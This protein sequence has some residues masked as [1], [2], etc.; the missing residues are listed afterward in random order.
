MQDEYPNEWKTYPYPMFIHPSTH[1]SSI[2]D[3][4]MKG[5]GGLEPISA[6]IGREV[7]SWTG[8]QFITGV[9]NIWGF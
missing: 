5:R 7:A 3:Y 6:D 1:P 9:L 4:P 2:T 8:C